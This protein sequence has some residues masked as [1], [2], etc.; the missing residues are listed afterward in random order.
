MRTPTIYFSFRP[1]QL[2]LA[3]IALLLTAVFWG[4]SYGITKEAL[5]Y[6]SVFA[7]LVIRFGMT[8]LILLPVYWHDARKG[9]TKDWRYAVPTGIILL[10][11][12]IAETYGIFHTSA[13]KAAFLISLCVLITPIMES[14]VTRTRPKNKIILCALMSLFGV[15]LL[16]SN[17]ITE[18]SPTHTTGKNHGLLNLGDICILLAAFLRACMVVATNVLLKGKSLSALSTTCIQA[19]VVT[20]GALLVFFLTDNPI[21]QLLP[22]S[23]SFWLEASYLVLFCTIFALFAQNFGVKHTSASRVSLLTGSEPAFGA[24]F[25][26]LWLGESFSIIQLVGAGCILGA[27]LLA[28]KQR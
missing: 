12:F 17:G 26:F 8:S 13:S 19:N 24:L 27:T 14:C 2:P 18:A 22:T 1:A 10:G 5:L 7:F 20:L 21:E 16:T 11:I 23:I 15:F 4:T 28:S 25:A 6:T 9:L 3:E